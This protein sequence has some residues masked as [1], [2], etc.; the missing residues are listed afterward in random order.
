MT[1]QENRRAEIYE[2]QTMLRLLSQINPNFPPVNPDGI[3]GP[4]TEKAVLA[5]QTSNGLPPTGIVDFGTWTAITNAY[6]NALRLTQ[7]G[8]ALFPFP[9]GDY[10]VKKGER[11]D[12]VYIIQIMLSGIDAAYDIFS[13]IEISG[14]YDEKTESAIRNFQRLSRLPESGE[15]DGITWDRLALDHN[16][17]ALNPI[18][19]G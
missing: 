9:P 1:K 11:S 12:L 19:T 5:F 15:V 6:Q 2:L 17:F 10:T 8:L 4:E 16:R 13:D 18:Y 7:R 3:Y 14:I